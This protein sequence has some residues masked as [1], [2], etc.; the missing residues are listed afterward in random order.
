M[1]ISQNSVKHWVMLFIK[2]AP[3]IVFFIMLG[4]KT[5]TP[6]E[7]AQYL[8]EFTFTTNL[9]NY[10]ETIGISLGNFG[11]LACGYFNYIVMV[12]LIDIL[13]EVVLFFPHV[14]KNWFNKIY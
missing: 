5:T 7:F 8:P 4:A 6:I 10:L 11:S 9:T 14:F 13:A 2:I 1:N 3:I 12:H